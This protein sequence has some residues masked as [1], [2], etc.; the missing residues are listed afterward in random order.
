MINHFST[1]GLVM[2]WLTLPVPLWV[3][4]LASLIGGFL[5]ESIRHAIFGPGALLCP[6]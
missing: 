5:D 4:L 1:K 2:N 3:I 6:W